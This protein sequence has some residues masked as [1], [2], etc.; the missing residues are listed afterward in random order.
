MTDPILQIMLFTRD[1]MELD[2]KFIINGR[3]NYE[4][5]NF[6]DDLLVVDGIPAYN[7]QSTTSKYDGQKEIQTIS[8][9]YSS[10]YNVTFYGEKALDN[11]VK[12]QAL[13][14]SERGLQTMIKYGISIYNVKSIQDIKLLTGTQYKNCLQIGFTMDYIE[15]NEIETLRIEKL[16]MRFL[17][18]K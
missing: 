1:V 10:E 5:L 18:N 2:E 17:F 4:K 9:L 13:A 15:K 3:S 6:N 14:K 16:D 8:T 7:A 11:A 12:W